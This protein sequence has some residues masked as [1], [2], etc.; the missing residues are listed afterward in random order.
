MYLLFFLATLIALL[1]FF[2][3]ELTQDLRR[4]LITVLAVRV[5][6]EHAVAVAKVALEC[7]HHLIG[8]VILRVTSILHIKY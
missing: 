4:R 7:L 3:Y 6:T 1:L 5:R 2:T 8:F